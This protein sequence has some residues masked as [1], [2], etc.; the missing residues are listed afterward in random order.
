MADNDGSGSFI[1]GFL[2]G[3]IIGFVAGVLLAPKAGSETRADLMEQSEALRLRAE[4]LGAKVRER[5]GPTVDVMRERVAPAVEGVRERV[6]PAVEGVRERVSPVAE[7]LAARVGRGA[8]SPETDGGPGPE[9]AAEE[10]GVPE[11]KKK[12]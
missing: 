11:A 5:V 1:T 4:E 7:R 2:F 3:G 9:A 12:A 10:K 8:A 6:A